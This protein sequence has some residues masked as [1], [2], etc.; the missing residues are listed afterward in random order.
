MILGIDPGERRIGLAV[1]D[2]ETRFA[3]PF[4]VIDQTETD[5]LERIGEVI[6]EL[7]VTLVVVGRPVGLSGIEGP[8]MEKQKTFLVGLRGALDVRVEVYDERLTTVVAE[9]GLRSG[10]ASAKKRKEL[11]DA[12]AAQVML[13]GYLDS[14]VKDARP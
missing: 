4:E 13:Q 9:Q 12:V 5:A 14:R 2:D 8:A 6:R 11:R 10:G 7:D 1:A 3:R